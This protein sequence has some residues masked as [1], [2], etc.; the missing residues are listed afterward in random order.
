MNNLLLFITLFIVD[1]SREFFSFFRPLGGD[2]GLVLKDFSG[3]VEIGRGGGFNIIPTFTAQAR[4][5]MFIRVSFGL[6]KI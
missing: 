6:N 2:S 4:N 1:I 3:T 5:L